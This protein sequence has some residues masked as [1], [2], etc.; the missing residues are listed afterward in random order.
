MK[1]SPKHN[2]KN[3]WVSISLVFT[4]TLAFLTFAQSGLMAQPQNDDKNDKLEAELLHDIDQWLEDAPIAFEEETV[5]KME[6]KMHEKAK[7]L[8]AYEAR[9]IAQIE[10]L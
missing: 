3:R 7:E 1:N 6:A 2:R 5:A 9:L 4:L 10:M 8:K